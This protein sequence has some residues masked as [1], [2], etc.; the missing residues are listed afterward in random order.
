MN[1]RHDLYLECFQNSLGS[2][3]LQRHLLAIKPS[4]LDEAVLAG[5]E[6]LQVQVRPTPPSTIHQV[7][8]DDEAPPT[9]AA[10]LQPEPLTALMEAMAQLTKQVN[11]L[12]T[13]ARPTSAKRRPVC[14]KCRQHGHLQRQC[15][16]T[17][18]PSGNDGSQR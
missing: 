16:S 12:K 17:Q 11:Q 4:T 13:L 18:E 7:E 14:W 5:N 3:A 10:P 6:Y 8:E 2:A 15:P 1:T 9:K